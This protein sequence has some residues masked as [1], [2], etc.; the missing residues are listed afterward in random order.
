LNK[1]ENINIV[2]LTSNNNNLSLAETN[3]DS[4]ATEDTGDDTKILL[5][6]KM[7]FKKA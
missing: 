2:S 5:Y 4:I 6:N 7:T 3:F 1:N